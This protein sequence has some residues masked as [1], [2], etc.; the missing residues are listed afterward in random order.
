MNNTLAISTNS[1]TAMVTQFNNAQV[2]MLSIYVIAFMLL[3]TVFNLLLGEILHQK[4]HLEGSQLAKQVYNLKLEQTADR[5]I[6]AAL[7]D[8]HGFMLEP[9]SM[10][11]HFS[12]FMAEDSEIFNYKTVSL[13]LYHWPFWVVESHLFI[14]LNLVMIGA[15]I[16]GYR[17]WRVLFRRHDSADEV[18]PQIGN[19]QFTSA[20]STQQ[21]TVKVSHHDMA[22]GSTKALIPKQQA[23]TG[24]NPAITGMY[25]IQ[26]NHQHLFALLYCAQ[27]FPDNV[28]LE[29]HFKLIMVK[30]FKELS[31][32]S[33]K[34]LSSGG[35]AITL[36]NIPQA[37]I[38]TYTKRLHQTIY[39]ASLPYRGDLSRKEIKIGVC[40]YRDGADQTIVYQLTKSALTLAKQSAWQHIHRVPFNY[41][42]STVL[43]NSFENLADYIGKKKFMLFF[44]PLFEFASGDIL[45]HE[46]L[47]RVRH[48]SLGMLS[49][50]QFIPQLKSDD[51]ITLLDKTVLD[52]V[53]KL[54]KSEPSPLT[55]SI[56]LHALNWFDDDYWHWF[57]KRMGNIKAA[58]KLQFEISEV[59]FYQHLQLLKFAFSRIEL[60]GSS[61]LIDN[62]SSSSKVTLLDKYKV[63]KGLKLSYDLIHNIDKNITQQKQVRQ[64]VTKAE[65]VNLP[66]YGVGVETQQELNMLKKLGVVGAQGFYFTEPLQE[67]TNVTVN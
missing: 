14:L 9:G 8:D 6:I 52:Q 46:A 66:V 45:Q 25:G 22:V 37:E 26:S 53:I 63:I 32:V 10:P 34:L 24:E 39:Q 29:R 57:G 12:A 11:F 50:K 20:K 35:L 21:T 60:V 17:W 4:V 61:V 31:R 30:G 59:D 56:N 18:S 47:I 64:I 55:V 16:W 2:Q 1:V 51:A 5:E 23:T 27:P 42:R 67:F 15:A 19:T 48:K 58:N 44:Q 65:R 28:D 33:V 41:T 13:K 7:A 62:V 49:A 54:L 43:A 36:E 3:L 40:N 38:D